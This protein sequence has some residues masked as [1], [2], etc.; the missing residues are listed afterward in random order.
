MT[1]SDRLRRTL[2]ARA[3]SIRL[4]DD[5]WTRIQARLHPAAVRRRL[6]FALVAGVP[7]VLMIVVLAMSVLKTGRGAQ[8]VTGPAAEGGRAA[9]GPPSASDVGAERCRVEVS[10]GPA[11]DEAL[12]RFFAA[13]VARDWEAAQP[14]I[15]KRFA[16]EVGGR[17]GFIGPSSPHVDRFTVFGDLERTPER[18]RVCARTYESTSME[19]TYR[20]D[21]LKLLRG[22]DGQWRVDEWTRG[23]VVTI[24][25]SS[26]FTV[27]FVAPE[28]Q[29]CGLDRSELISAVVSVPNGPD[30]DRHAVEELL[31]GP[32]GRAA[33]GKARTLLPLDTRIRS[34]SI[35]D[36]LA[37][38]DLTDAADVGGG[39]CLQGGRREQARRTLLSLPGVHRAE[40]TAGGRLVDES[41][42]P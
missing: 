18:V 17:D 1:L 6:T 42:Q 23:R 34:L 33:E 3:D 21:A 15:T 38:L 39:A 27:W 4:S 16:S 10:Q 12:E 35:E 7:L 31:S 40:V 14:F 37:R 28:A 30:A 25:G 8:V 13:R 11:P 5:A 2:G 32:V 19:R 9:S 41:F 29:N 20:D 26:D 22:G 24:A 36:G